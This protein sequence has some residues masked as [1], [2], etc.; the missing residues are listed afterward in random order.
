MQRRS[1]YLKIK[2]MA[3]SIC[4]LACVIAASAQTPDVIKGK[5][6]AWQKRNLQ[7]KLF[8]H[9]NKGTYLAGEIIWFKVYCVDGSNNKLLDISKVAYVELLDNSRSALL[10]A[11]VELKNGMGTGCFVIPLVFNSG[12]YR[13]RAYTN[14]MRNFDPA[15]YFSQDITIINTQRPPS[16]VA[17]QDSA[18]YDVQFFPEGGHLVSGVNNRV[19]FKITGANG[20]GSEGSGI[21]VDGRNDTV[22][23][24]STLNFGM[25]SFSLT[26]VTQD[27]YRAIVRIGKNNIIRPLPEISKAGYVMN[28]VPG[29]NRYDVNVHAVATGSNTVYLVVHNHQEIKIAEKIALTDG[30]GHFAIDNARLNAGINYITL[31]DEQQHPL[32][33]RL[34]FKRPAKK[35]LINANTDSSNYH[36]RSRVGLDI[37][38]HD[39]PDSNAAANLS[40]SVYRLD[41]L[42]KVDADGIAGYLSL[43]ADL[44]GYI[45]SPDYYLDNDNDEANHALDNLLLTQG[46]TQFDWDK[47]VSGAPRVFT[48]LPEYKGP[49]I[50]AKLTNIATG[51]PAK[52]IFG[53]LTVTGASNQLAITESDSTG[54][55]LFSLKNFYGPREIVAQTNWLRDSTY[56][57][58]IVNAYSEEYDPRPIAAFRA[59]S[60][61]KSL[62]VDNGIGMQVQNI[63]KAKELRQFNEPPPALPVFYGTPTY[64]YKLDD[65]TRFPTMYEVIHEYIRL[66]RVGHSNGDTHFELITENKTILPGVPLALLDS[67][68]IFDAAKVL[69]IDP[70]KVKTLDVINSNYIYGPEVLTGIV[71]LRSYDGN[72]INT[73][74]DPRAV[75]LDFDGLQLQRKFYSPVYGNDQQRN[76]PVPDFR[77]ALYWNPDINTTRAATKLSFF[78]SDKTGRYI[79]VVEGI[80]HDGAAG[81]KYFYFEVK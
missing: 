54:K 78:T 1:T 49:L 72:S 58:D 57:I 25:G 26:P 27:G 46:W 11:K 31:F 39:R 60:A 9:I 47:V 4:L 48:F 51:E 12:N 65:Y 28:V 13:L 23:R 5:F 36:I 18:S 41:S 10:Q 76:S 53:Y 20:K 24:F 42:Q 74:I 32:C 21:V 67:R 75:V 68:P 40:V 33:E 14:W 77:T 16:V 56:R 19:A 37:T 62:L 22:A 61:L 70:L 35:L 8:V 66:L 81:S 79:G 45:E 69:A 15:Y 52:N 3:C 6:N 29:Q 50:T 64:P 2:A 30:A 73:G 63:F 7:E 80:S 71:S 43:S 59:D 44:K 55:L 17:R 38:A 34:I